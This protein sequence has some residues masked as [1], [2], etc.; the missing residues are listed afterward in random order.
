MAGATA[1]PPSSPPFGRSLAGALGIN[2][3]QPETNAVVSGGMAYLKSDAA[4]TV[5]ATLP[6]W[7]WAGGLRVAPRWLRDTA[8]DL[9]AQNRYR[10]FGRTDACMVPP[11]GL[12]ARVLDDP[13]RAAQ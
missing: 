6:G 2:P 4:L 7:R 8:Y 5:L 3:G 11:S 1:S 10:L 13:P 12:R 9:I